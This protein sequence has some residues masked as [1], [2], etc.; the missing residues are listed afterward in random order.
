MYK[1]GYTATV[2]Q[3][4]MYKTVCHGTKSVAVRVCTTA[5]VH[6]SMC[7]CVDLAAAQWAPSVLCVE[8]TKKQNVPLKQYISSIRCGSIGAIQ[9][10]RS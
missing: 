3:R 4:L 7:G 1:S 9:C 8:T 2:Q 6:R 10:A 5:T